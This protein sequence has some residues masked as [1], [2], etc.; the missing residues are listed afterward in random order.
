VKSPNE[1]SLSAEQVA[2]F[3]MERH[4]LL[5]RASRNLAEICGDVC[6][7]QAQVMSA[8]EMALWAR[9]RELSRPEVHRALWEE[10]TLVK[11]S[12][13]RGTLHLLAA[14]DFPVYIRALRSSRLRAMRRVM[15]KY[16]DVTPELGDRVTQAA[17]DALQDGPLTRAELAERVL[18]QGIASG[19]NK[20][21][22]AEGWWSVVRQ[23]MVEGWVCYGPPRGADAT[24]IRVDQWLPAVRWPS[25]SEAQQTLLRRYLSA[26]GPAR[27]QD[28]SYWAGMPAAEARPIWEAVLPE[29][30]AVR[31]NSTRLYCLRKDVSKILS[32]KKN[33]P[34][35]R[36]LP[37]F[38]CF[39]LGHV[40]KDHLVSPRDYARVFRKAGWISP[41]VLKDGRVAAI[42]SLARRK[43]QASIRVESLVPLGRTVREE[44][45]REAERLSLFM[46]VP[47][48]LQLLRESS[49]R[50]G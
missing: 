6:G 30:S 21:W 11:T 37:N 2:L 28:F 40:E 39:L 9:A 3:R 12:V 25:E 8:A 20:K 43:Q 22:F 46:N 17:V 27:I 24:L 34:V 26:Y 1:I 32:V 4:H 35:V 44:I 41:V 15:A 48:Q 16:G 23:A 50:T 10:K 45:K 14:S 7:I 42:W 47:L 38:E 18:S 13:M 33:T 31:S 49:R 29:L 19:K 5:R 36:L